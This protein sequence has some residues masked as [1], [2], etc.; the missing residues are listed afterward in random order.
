MKLDLAH[1]ERA[2]GPVVTG[3]DPDLIAKA[4]RCS[5]PFSGI[6]VLEA[7]VRRD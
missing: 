1:G 2:I 6:P 5:V 4:S 3:I 7:T